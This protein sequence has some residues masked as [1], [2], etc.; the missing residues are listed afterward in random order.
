[1]KSSVFICFLMCVAVWSKADPAPARQDAAAVAAPARESSWQDMKRLDFTVAGRPALVIVPDKP[2]PG[3]PW[4][5]RTEFF[6]AF[7][8]ADIALAKKGF[9]IGYINMEN[10]YGSPDAMKLMDAYYDYMTREYRLDP[11]PVLEGLSR[12][13][14]FAFNWA[15]RNPEKVAGL[16]VDAPVCDFKSWPGGKGTGKGSPEDWKRLCQAYRLTPEQAL[17]YKK[18]PVDTLLPLAKAKIPILAVVGDDDDTVPV[19]ENT[20][21]VEKKYRKLGGPI[22]VIHKP[23]ISHHPHGLLNPA[24][25]VN[26]AFR[27][28]GAV[29]PVRVV[30]IGDSI[31]FGAGSNREERWSARLQNALGEKYEVFNLGISGTTLQSKGDSPYTAKDNYTIARQI[32][33]DIILIALGTNDSKPA[34]WKNAAA[35]SRDYETMI[36]ELRTGNPKA[37]IYCLLPVPAYPGNYGIRDSIIRGEVIP[38]IRK[39]AGKAKCRV[40]DLYT[41]M[42]GEGSKVPDKVHPNGAGHAIMAQHIYKAITGRKMPE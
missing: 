14:L 15:S 23:G 32:E 7:P 17:A 13:A 41:P 34:N 11:K 1:M 35:F 31:T 19:S 24:A 12:G 5:W 28:A 8:A 30:C 37:E 27:A 33:G 9:H 26:F 6:N 4:I 22:R 20:A 10:M 38:A 29:P 42:K 36:K 39:V 3:N 25:I 16:Y 2:L 18:N 40:I 21:V